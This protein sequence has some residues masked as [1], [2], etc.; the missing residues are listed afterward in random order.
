MSDWTD[1]IVGARM[2]VDGTFAPEVDAS[3][4]SRQEWGLVMTSVEFEI[5]NAADPSNARLVANSD[6]LEAVVPELK[7]V[8][9][10]QNRM[11]G[12]G[13]GGGSDG[14]ILNNVKSALGLGNGTGDQGVDEE[15]L[16]EARSLT[17]R[18]AEEL[19]AHLEE[20]G[21]W[22]EICEAAAGSSGD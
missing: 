10:M 14:G 21:R 18:Y 8:A 19:Q 15:R 11:Q 5:E 13:G 22:A 6:N 3:G 7:R 4:F 1:K 16:A 17:Q 12:G 2:A 9:E 20:K